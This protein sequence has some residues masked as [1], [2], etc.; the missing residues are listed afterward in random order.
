MY[1]T[2]S[3]A[4]R[5]EDAAIMTIDSV[6]WQ[7]VSHPKYRCSS[8]A[9]PDYGHVVFQYTLSGQGYL[10]ID[11][12]TLALS[13][14]HA[15]VVKVDEKH[16]YYYKEDSTEPWEF[17]WINIRGDEANRIWNLVIEKEGHVIKRGADS[18]VIQ[19]LWNIIRLI[20]QEKVTDRYQLSVQVYQW[21][22]T[23]VQSSRD[24]EKDIGAMSTT[25]LEKCKQ[26]IREHY[27]SP[28][29]LDILAKHC[30]INK[31]YLCRLFQRSEQTSPLAY[32]KDRRVEAALTMLRT[33]ELPISLI[34]QK[35]G[36][37]S[38]SYFGKVFRQYMSM[39][40]KE[41]RLN[42]LEFPYDAIYYE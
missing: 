33:T 32:L 41:Y 14:G 15:L 17:V 37:E 30:D 3:F 18:P 23:L 5:N 40:P 29:T 2:V 39:S 6:G 25:T 8:D 16:C 36:F 35:C 27:A 34:G 28:I 4:F 13:K 10:D 1:Q 26:Y 31:H 21:L 22:L 19:E 38:P 20:H 11:G 42:K 9:R 12:R 24:A 7:N